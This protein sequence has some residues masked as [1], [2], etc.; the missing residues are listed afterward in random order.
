[1]PWLPEGSV[2]ICQNQGAI[3]FNGG[4]VEGLLERLGIGGNRAISSP[5]FVC[6]GNVEEKNGKAHQKRRAKKQRGHK[7]RQAGGA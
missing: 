6:R 1:M 3:L 4:T 2:S 7:T 5:L